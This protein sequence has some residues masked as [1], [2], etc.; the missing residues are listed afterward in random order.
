MVIGEEAG[1]AALLLASMRVAETEL[2]L[3]CRDPNEPRTLSKVY[4][5]GLMI[6]PCARWMSTTSSMPQFSFVTC[7]YVV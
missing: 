1:S 3:E 5:V 6:I 4:Q 2:L 7:A